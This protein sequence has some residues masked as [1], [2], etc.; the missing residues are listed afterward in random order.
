MKKLVVLLV[1]CMLLG[2]CGSKQTGVATDDHT[3]HEDEA[4]EVLASY[5]TDDYIEFSH[6]DKCIRMYMVENTSDFPISVDFS[7]TL[8]SDDG[9]TPITENHGIIPALDPGE[10]APLVT[11]VEIPEE[12][13]S[14]ERRVGKEC[15]L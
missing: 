13:R 5:T 12:Y 1:A 8:L 11:W 2:G 7:G 3:I 10:S 15:R 6:E 4:E 9:F 14:E